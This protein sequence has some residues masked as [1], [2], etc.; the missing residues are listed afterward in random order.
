MIVSRRFFLWSAADVELRRWLFR[1]PSFL[2]KIVAARG[3]CSEDRLWESTRLWALVHDWPSVS[4]P[5]RGRAVIRSATSAMEIGGG[6]IGFVARGSDFRARTEPEGGLGVFVQWDPAVFGRPSDCPLVGQRLSGEDLARVEAALTR[7]M[8][9]THAPLEL[10]AA[11]AELFRVLGAL[12]VLSTRPEAGDLVVPAR[13]SLRTIMTGRA[14]DSVLSRAADRPMVVDLTTALGCS[15]R[16]AR[17][18]VREYAD[19]YALQGATTWRTL[20]GLWRTYLAGLLMTAPDA[21]TERVATVLGYGSPTAFCHALSNA[22]LPSPGE[23]RR[24]VADMA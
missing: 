6:Q 2:V 18:L 23:M 19:A 3:V 13:P 24:L 5:V 9:E 15:E 17:G 22:G 12:G 20:V 4:I 7:L 11:V 21:T 8:A 10:E 14:I 1:H 16:H